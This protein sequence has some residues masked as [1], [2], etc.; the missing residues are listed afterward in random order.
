VTPARVAALLLAACGL[1]AGCATPPIAATPDPAAPLV[2][3][4]QGSFFVG[5]RDLRSDALSLLP[6][7][8]PSGT[9]TV[10]KVS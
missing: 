1:V 3:A 8:L 6:A 10:E 4:K 2:L 5:G 9:I 7:Y